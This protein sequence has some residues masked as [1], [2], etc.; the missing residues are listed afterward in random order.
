LV[1][2]TSTALEQIRGS[3]GRRGK[4]PRVRAAAAT[5]IE[6]KNNDHDDV[7]AATRGKGAFELHAVHVR[8]K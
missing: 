5:C 6:W 8:K 2:A 4:G 1:N 3:L 7:A